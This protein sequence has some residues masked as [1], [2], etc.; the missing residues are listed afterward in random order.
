MMMVVEEAVRQ[1]VPF[2]NLVNRNNW[3]RLFVLVCI[4]HRVNNKMQNRWAIID[5][6]A[7][8]DRVNCFL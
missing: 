2:M 1:N 4:M 6:F 3:M 7:E 5:T 8:G